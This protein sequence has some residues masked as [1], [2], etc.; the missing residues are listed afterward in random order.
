MTEVIPPPPRMGRPSSYCDEVATEICD[1]MASG[2]GLRQI[3]SADD[4]P[5]R[6]TVLRWLD[7]NPDFRDRYAR[8]REALMDFYS[9][10]ILKIAFDDS[11]DFFIERDKRGRDMMVANHARVQRDRLKV[12]SLKWIMS[13]LAPRRYGER[14]VDDAPPVSESE[15]PVVSI[16]R[17]F[18]YPEGRGPE[19]YGY[20]RRPQLD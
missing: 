10:E 8:A 16:T 7:S 3:C 6:T 9:E 13:K 17:T 4:M 18:I 1:R 20:T 12:D 5:A 14:P 11:G 19:D 2:Q 15:Q